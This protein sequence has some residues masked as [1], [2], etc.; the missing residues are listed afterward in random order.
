MTITLHDGARD[1]TP[2]GLHDGFGRRIDYLRISLTDRC[3]LRC[4]YCM[5]THGLAFAPD[6]ALLSAAEIETVVRA[7]ASVGFRKVRLTG[8]EPT[9]R[10]DVVD[11]VGR[12][13]A[14]PGIRDVS[15]TTNGIR[16]V[17]L[18]GELKAAGLTRV[19]IHVDSVDPSRLADLMRWGK[20]DDLWA[21]VAAA[22]A[23]GLLPIKL[24]CVV[25]RGYNEADIVPLARL[26]IEHD[27]T[28]RFI[29]L[30]P[31]GSGAEAQFSIDRYVS[32]ADI[33]VRIEAALGPL[34]PL[35][36]AD[37]SDEA[38][39]FTLPGACGRVGFISPVSEPYCGNCNRMRLTADGKFHLCLLHDDE[40][41]VRAVLREV[42]TGDG[43]VGEVGD[44]VERVAAVLARAV[45]MK[46]I[47][48]ALAAGVHTEG[49]RMHAIGG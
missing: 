24:N 21:G 25:A 44:A 48:H 7:A 45:A 37:A 6:D 34:T 49:R 1:G 9:L 40:I 5:P 29:E 14:V 4:R 12:I 16:L 13:A 26:T 36:N 27:W 33:A 39:N 20:A 8:G 22:E 19:N 3:N 42:G 10:R 18:A 30:M 43:A 31:L 28:V 15:M 2:D 17:A 41:D 46:P 38:R 32:N 35:A 23:A 11:I 47:G